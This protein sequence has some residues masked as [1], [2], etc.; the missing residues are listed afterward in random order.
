MLTAAPPFTLPNQK[1]Q[2]RAL[3]DYLKHGPVLLAFH[4]GTWCPNCRKKFSELAQHSPEYVKRGAQVVTVVAQSSDVVRRYVEDMGLPF[5]I[6]IDESRDVLK[7]YGVW[8]R[9]GLDAWNIAR[10]ALFLID[11][12]GA[13]KFSFVSDRQDEFPSH[14]EI[15]REI[16][17]LDAG[18]RV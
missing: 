7:A 11:S 10:P 14:D 18:R 3:Q 1:G 15:M 8:H 6:L 9:L 17:G 16:D 2:V 5:N 12:T 13:I 4:R